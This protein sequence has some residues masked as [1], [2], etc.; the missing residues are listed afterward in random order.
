MCPQIK[1]IVKEIIRDFQAKNRGNQTRFTTGKN[2]YEE[3]ILLVL[4][5]L[6]NIIDRFSIAG[7]GGF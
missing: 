3:R 7:N 4:Q 5:F 2:R 1:V 6:K